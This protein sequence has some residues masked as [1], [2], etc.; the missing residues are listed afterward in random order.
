MNDGQIRSLAI[1]SRALK[2]VFTNLKGSVCFYKLLCFF[3]FLFLLVLLLCSLKVAT[4]STMQE[5]RLV[6]CF[7][8]FVAHAY[9]KIDMFVMAH[10]C[11]PHFFCLLC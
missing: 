1:V 4:S 11:V 8:V 10:G 6:V 7:S 5:S 3:V 9:L 2:N